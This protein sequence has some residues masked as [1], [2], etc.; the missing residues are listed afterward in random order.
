MWRRAK[1]ITTITITAMMWQASTRPSA[2]AGWARGVLANLHPLWLVISECPSTVRVGGPVG[3]DQTR[4]A[5]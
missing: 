3:S 4:W 1:P 2:K 5:I